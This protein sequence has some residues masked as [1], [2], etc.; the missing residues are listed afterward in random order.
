MRRWA[1]GRE[2]PTFGVLYGWQVYDNG[3]DIYFESLIASLREAALYVSA[4]RNVR[5][6]WS[7][8]VAVSTSVPPPVSVPRRPA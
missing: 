7:S 8:R 2:H 3:I 4:S 6:R 1:L 5:R